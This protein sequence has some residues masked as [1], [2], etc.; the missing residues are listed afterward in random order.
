MVVGWV[1]G[2]PIAPGVGIFV[3]GLPNICGGWVP[4]VTTHPPL[5]KKN[6]EQHAVFALQVATS[7]MPQDCT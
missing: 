5:V 4:Q 1:G 3:G 7:G 6:P 2:C